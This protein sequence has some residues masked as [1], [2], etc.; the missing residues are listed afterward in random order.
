LAILSRVAC[1]ATSVA[2]SQL[3]GAGK[4]ENS[5]LEGAG[6]LDIK[7]FALRLLR[8]CIGKS[9]CPTGNVVISPVSIFTAMAMVGLGSDGQTEKEFQKVFG[10]GYLHQAELQLSALDKMQS[11][12]TLANAIFQTEDVRKD[13]IEDLKKFKA[14]ISNDMKK[15]AINK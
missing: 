4:V 11:Q 13:F 2:N 15:D 9:T 1:S 12:I 10:N 14:E 7:V 5:Q 3:E 8:A 6:N